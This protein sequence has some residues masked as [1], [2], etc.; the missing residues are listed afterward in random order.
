MAGAEF[1]SYAFKSIWPL[2]THAVFMLLC[3]LVVI[4]GV[5]GGIEK[6][7]NI[8]MPT[9]FI[10][11]LLL[12]IRGVTLKGAGAGIAFLFAPDFSKLTGPVM[13]TALGHAFFTLS[14]GMGVM[15]TYGSYLEREENLFRSA[16]MIIVLDTL[17]ALLAGVAIFTAVFAM[18]F[19]PS[20]GPGL[21]FYVLPAIF[22]KMPLGLLVGVLFFLLL[23]IAALTSGVSLLEVVSAYFID[24]RGWSRHR[25]TIIFTIVIFLLGVPSA[26]SFGV[27]GH[28]TI[29]G[30][31][32]FDFFDY[33]SF[34]YLLPIGGFL[35]VLFTLF[36]WGTKKFLGEL[37]RGMRLRIPA[38]LAVVFLIC[39]AIFVAW[40]FVAQLRG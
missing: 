1:E 9:L 22:A 34:K 39:S 10:I 19:E 31:I 23:S 7:N 17:V 16:L 20:Q 11:I 29:L 21:V 27:L 4:R 24:E 6:W 18:G 14:L 3:A 8:L 26:L 25:A 15:I 32:L 40:T 37:H 12:V 35:M 28:I 38:L 2:I 36:Y 30:M 5:K 13:L 33:L